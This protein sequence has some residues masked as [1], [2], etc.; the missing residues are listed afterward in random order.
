MRT[1]NYCEILWRMRINGLYIIWWLWIDILIWRETER[2]SLH[3]LRDMG[4]WMRYTV[5]FGDALWDIATRFLGGGAR[6]PEI[7]NANRGVIG[8]NPISSTLVK[9]WLLLFDI[10]DEFQEVKV[11]QNTFCLQIHSVHIDQFQSLI[12]FISS[13]GTLVQLWD[14]DILGAAKLCIDVTNIWDLN[15]W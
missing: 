4:A 11:K 1:R 6:W 8:S 5:R 10:I 9:S 2:A 12:P 14:F 13:I 7:S 3:C 15:H